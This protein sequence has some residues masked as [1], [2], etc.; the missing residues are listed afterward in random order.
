[1]SPVLP[2]VWSEAA[3]LRV[4]GL[5]AAWLQR[6][7]FREAGRAVDGWRAAEEA[8]F[9][10]LDRLGE[11]AGAAVAGLTDRAQRRRLL[12][13]RRDAHNRRFARLRR[14][15]PLP[16]AVAVALDGSLAAIA[17]AAAA[18]RL[19]RAIFSV[20][21]RES[22]LELRRLATEPAMVDAV[23]S[24]SPG[25][26][27]ELAELASGKLEGKRLRHAEN[28]LALY[29]TR[30]AGKT[31]PRG[32]LGWVACGSLDPDLPQAQSLGVG[33]PH[34]TVLLN[35]AW[36]DLAHTLSAR[37]LEAPLEL[38]SCRRADGDLTL[39]RRDE[40]VRGDLPRLQGSHEKL[41]RV[42]G[43]GPLLDVV[44]PRLPATRSQLEAALGERVREPG[45][46]IERLIG[47]G[48][49][50]PAPALPMQAWRE[51]GGVA[52]GLARRGPVSRRLGESLDQAAAG[53]GDHGS[54]PARAR[55]EKARQMGTKLRTALDA[56]GGGALPTP[57]P[58]LF[59]DA[60]LVDAAARLGKTTLAGPLS[61]LVTVLE[62]A[63]A[64]S[65]R[66]ARRRT[67]A[68]RLRS[69]FASSSVPVL[70]AAAELLGPTEAPQPPTSNPLG[71]PDVARLIEA[72]ERLARALIERVDRRPDGTLQLSA[73]DLAHAWQ[74]LDVAR[75]KV[76]LA[77]AVVQVAPLEETPLVLSGALQGG[78][79]FSRFLGGGDP[80]GSTTAALRA[81]LVTHLAPALPVE[82]CGVQGF[83]ANLHPPLASF[84]VDYPG[85][86]SVPASW[87]SLRLE[88]L[89]VAVEGDLGL[90][91]VRDRAGREL[92]LLDLGFL[93]DHLK[94]PLR[95]WL[96]LLCAQAEPDLSLFRVRGRPAAVSGARHYPRVC[97]G[98]V[99]V[100]RA[101]WRVPCSEIFREMPTHDDPWLQ[102]AMV[103]HLLARLGTPRAVFARADVEIAKDQP[104]P[105][106][107]R[108]FE[109]KPIWLDADA[110]IT[111]R[112]LPRM[113]RAPT[114]HLDLVEALPR[115]DLD[116]I[117]TADERRAA[118]WVLELA[119]HTRHAAHATEDRS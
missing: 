67:L 33:V 18:E 83:N 29:L 106:A 26:E 113:L 89:V 104:P 19:A 14:D 98:G 56:A 99:V 32:R 117:Q 23:A 68:E 24:A 1:M 69:R 88:D 97:V 118:E 16:P 93:S 5:P 3:L 65:L 28:T 20:E 41:L 6:L 71:L 87:P 51:P 11:V 43:V 55:T 102:F 78:R 119:L 96:G 100:S 115:P 22:A 37:A 62:V 38:A 48:L 13:L 90:P 8:A 57:S 4:G 30:A 77:E 105:A 103:R 111:A 35:L 34:H 49:L 82:L 45:A 53:L 60:C 10:A 58:V 108:D 27:E 76:A 25:L 15:P 61:D 12:D 7:R 92:A 81:H 70:E 54:Q 72:R 40:T 110:P 50:L 85:L 2:S 109:H 39:V 94:P 63:D 21:A 116:G 44:A 114:T 9:T 64:S 46:L 101:R 42:R 107:T 31:S 84:A 73:L 91:V 75:P 47:L 80:A 66:H 36:I 86:P 112:L 17:E 52:R 79:L 95:R 59:E 74:G